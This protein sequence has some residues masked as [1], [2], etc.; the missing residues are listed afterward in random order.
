MTCPS[1]SA[2]AGVKDPHLAARVN[3][4][5]P[6]CIAHEA[7]SELASASSSHEQLTAISALDCACA[8]ADVAAVVAQAS[9]LHTWDGR[10][11]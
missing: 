8:S 2:F 9:R 11:W 7:L 1:C 3:L 4:L 5:H 10:P 6:M